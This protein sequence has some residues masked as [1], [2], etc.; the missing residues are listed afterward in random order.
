MKDKLATK[1][2]FR[3]VAEGCLDSVLLITLK[4]SISDK[5]SRR[6]SGVCSSSTRCQENKCAVQPMR[7]SIF[8]II[9]HFRTG[10]FILLT[11]NI[12]FNISEIDYQ[13]YGQFESKNNQNHFLCKTYPEVFGRLTL[14][15]ALMPR[16]MCTPHCVRVSQ[17]LNQN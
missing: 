3:C 6:V 8:Y 4:H 7:F 16:T 17:N 11:P 5:L 2:K 9:F 1:R 14:V 13:K 12:S 10:M 15:V